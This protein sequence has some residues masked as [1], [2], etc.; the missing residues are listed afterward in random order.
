MGMSASKGAGHSS[1]RQ[2]LRLPC[3]KATTDMAHD[4]SRLRATR[5]VEETWVVG[6]RND[7]TSFT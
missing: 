6:K 4:R 1:T 5:E 2:A 3:R 7:E